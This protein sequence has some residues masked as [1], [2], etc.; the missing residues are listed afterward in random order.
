MTGTS[1]R[2]HGDQVFQPS[3]PKPDLPHLTEVF[4]A[5]GYQTGAVGKL[6]A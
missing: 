6:H 1:P 3:L 2:K 5:N 4:R